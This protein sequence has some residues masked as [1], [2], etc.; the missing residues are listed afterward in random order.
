MAPRARSRRTEDDESGNANPTGSGRS[1]SRGSREA[2]RPRGNTASRQPEK[3]ANSTRKGKLTFDVH[4]ADDHDRVWDGRV[5][6]NEDIIG[7]DRDRSF[8]ID[9]RYAGD[10]LDDVPPVRPNP[11]HTANDTPTDVPTTTEGLFGAGYTPMDLP[12]SSDNLFGG[13]YIPT[14]GFRPHSAFGSIWGHASNPRFLSY[15]DDLWRRGSTWEEPIKVPFPTSP[16][17]P[18]NTIPVWPT[19]HPKRPDTKPAPTD[20]D[21]DDGE[22]TASSRPESRH[23]TIPKE[24]TLSDAQ[25]DEARQLVAEY[26][27]DEEKVKSTTREQLM[28]LSSPQMILLQE[29]AHTHTGNVFTRLG[30]KNID[31]L[32]DEYIRQYN[33]EVTTLLLG[34]EI[35]WSSGEEISDDESPMP[36]PPIVLPFREQQSEI[37]KRLAKG[38]G[39]P[40]T[41]KIDDDIKP[42]RKNHRV[43]VKSEEDEGRIEGEKPVEVNIDE[44]KNRIALQRI[45]LSQMRDKLTPTV[46]DQ[47]I[48]FDEHNHAWLR[49]E[50]I[51]PPRTNKNQDC[52]KST[53]ASNAPPVDRRDQ[54]D[55]DDDDK[56]HRDPFTPRL[57]PRA[58]STAPSSRATDI[59]VQYTEHRYQLIVEFVR[60]N[61]SKRLVLSDNMKGPR[62]D[63]KSMTKYNGAPLRETYWEWMRSLVYAF[64][65]AQLGGPDRDEE[66]VLILDSLLE[67]KAKSWFHA[68]L[69]R[70]DM[71]SPSFV[72]ALIE[73]YARFIHESAMQDAR[74]AFQRVGWDDADETV[75]GWRDHLQQLIRGIEVPP[76]DYSIKDK[77]MARLPSNIQSRVFADKLSIEYNTWDELAEG[78]LDAEYAIRAERRFSK[79]PRST[80]DNDTKVEPTQG[81]PFRQNTGHTAPHQNARRPSTFSKGMLG[82][83]TGDRKP[84]KYADRAPRKDERRSGERAPNNKGPMCFKCGQQGHIASNPL[85]PD[86]GKKPT[87]EQIRAAH[88]IILDV[89]AESV[90]VEEHPS[91]CGQQSEDEKSDDGGGFDHAEFEIYDSPD[92]MS[93]DDESTTDTRMHQMNENECEYAES[94]SDDEVVYG[95]PRMGADEEVQ[96][97]PIS[98]FGGYPK[99]VPTTATVEMRLASSNMERPSQPRMGA[100]TETG[101]TVPQQ[102]KIQLRVQKEPRDRP[103]ITDKRCLVTMVRINSLDAVTLWD[104]GSTSTAMSPAFADVSKAL[105]A[106][107]SNPVTLQLGTVGSRAKINYG[108][109]AAITTE[110]YSGPEYFDVVNI[111]K[112]DAIVGMPFMHRNGVVLDF[113]KKCVIINGKTMSGRILNGDEADKM[114]R[115]HRLRRP[116]EPRA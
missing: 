94:D 5:V 64:K 9:E 90:G 106:Q 112:Y 24:R 15:T 89:M 98:E 97:L 47:G 49:P 110:G 67:G 6:E 44:L 18:T 3:A 75:Q 33:A 92:R 21:H 31:R 20:L 58:T 1:S 102:G 41:I 30:F 68:R 4:Q 50:E 22:S 86:F 23:E 42:A 35:K 70:D 78:A 104:S 32:S 53:G 51:S 69:E 95:N 101:D 43:M 55:D 111:D 65:A 7:T 93:E 57:T 63:V 115:R 107:L 116:E 77:F 11:A 62:F 113:N 108:T 8:S 46:A 82:A 28:K 99:D 91:T 81:K 14:T 76:D 80:R 85:C 61:L 45:H 25:R 16:P 103:T 72:E 88:S 36:K 26:W 60:K 37:A 38:K 12:Q 74:E 87:Y 52:W 59:K 84:E 29:M 105:V 71:A 109:T 40:S 27:G 17:R 54:D 79:S 114:A 56:H 10:A 83:P 2:R 19:W 66:R 34:R 73:I 100:M 13:G 39:T 96:T 48:V